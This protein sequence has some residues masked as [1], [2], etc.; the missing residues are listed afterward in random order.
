MIEIIDKKPIGTQKMSH[1]IDF[2]SSETKVP[3]VNY[4]YF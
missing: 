3:F 4:E 1:S 2:V